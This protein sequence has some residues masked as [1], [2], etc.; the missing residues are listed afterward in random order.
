MTRDEAA[1]LYDMTRTEGWEFLR[2]W[3]L[4]QINAKTK[5]LVIADME[6]P[7]AAASLQGEIRG[8]QSVLLHVDFAVSQYQKHMKG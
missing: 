2:A 8:L 3:L 1:A 6:R 5:A 7:I 4:Q